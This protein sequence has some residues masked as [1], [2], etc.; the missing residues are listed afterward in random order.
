MDDTSSYGPETI[1][2]IQQE[3]GTY[4][5][6]IHHYS[7]QESI[8]EAGAK[9]EVYNGSELK[10]VFY[11]PTTGGEEKYIWEVFNLNGDTITNVN[12]YQTHKTGGS[13]PACPR[14]M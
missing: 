1:T 2:I 11:A 12:K 7:G 5:Y 3:G 9:I 10:R 14:V 13:G 8:A 6:S 4:Y